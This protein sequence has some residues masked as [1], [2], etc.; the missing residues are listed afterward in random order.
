MSS[1]TG[2]SSSAVYIG[3]DNCTFYKF[4]STGDISWQYSSGG[5]VRKLL[6][7]PLNTLL[8]LI[9][10]FYRSTRYLFSKEM[11]SLSFLFIYVADRSHSIC[12]GNA[13]DP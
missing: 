10:K 6:P 9:N 7:L 11:L 3:T 4:T 1:P 8:L 12:V 13:F 2:D 5:S